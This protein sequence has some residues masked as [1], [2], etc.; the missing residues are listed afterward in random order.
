MSGRYLLCKGRRARQAGISMVELM[1]SLT[2]SLI[3]L[4]ALYSIFMTTRLSQQ[5]ENGL[6]QMQEDQRM[7]MTIISQMIQSA[8]YYSNRMSSGRDSLFPVI[9]SSSQQLPFSVGQFISGRA[10]DANTPDVIGVRFQIGTNEN[11]ASDGVVNCLGATDPAVYS[12]VITVDAA[13]LQLTC[14]VNGQQPAVAVAGGKRANGMAGA[15]IPCKNAGYQGISNLKL[16]YGYDAS[17]SGSVTQYLAASGVTDWAAVR[18]VKVALTT[19][20]CQRQGVL[21][22]A[23]TISRVV[24]VPN[25]L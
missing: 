13:S 14:S 9:A 1:V 25:Q 24:F 17:G 4:L 16:Q 18:S 5:S 10:G 11:A 7:A 21:P 19:L 8:G 12:N 22:A 15:A 20:Y 23:V 6:A 3:L 2:I